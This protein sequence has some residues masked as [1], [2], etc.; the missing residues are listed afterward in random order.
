MRKLHV[1]L[2]FI[3]LLVSCKKEPKTILINGNVADKYTCDAVSE[4]RCF[5]K[6]MA[7]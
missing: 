6:Q 3:L 2:I 5:C 4:L 7:L 1:L